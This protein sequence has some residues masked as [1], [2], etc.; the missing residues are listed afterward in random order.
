MLECYDC[1]RPI[2]E[3]AEVSQVQIRGKGGRQVV[4][5]SHLQCAKAADWLACSVVGGDSLLPL[6]AAIVETDDPQYWFDRMRGRFPHAVARMELN[7]FL[8][9]REYAALA[10][11]AGPC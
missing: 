2:A 4:M 6:Y 7:R 5:T 10:A 9:D 1:E 3:G 11:E 8:L